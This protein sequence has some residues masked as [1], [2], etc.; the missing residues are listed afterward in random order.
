ME[1]PVPDFDLE[2]GVPF[3]RRVVYL[4][5][6]RGDCPSVLKMREKGRWTHRESRYCQ[7]PM[8]G[9][10]ASQGFTKRA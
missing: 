7:K 5:Y 4:P 6:L 2:L 9:A 3:A 1:P 10:N 8:L